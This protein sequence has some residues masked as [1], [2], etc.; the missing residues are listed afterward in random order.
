MRRRRAHPGMTAMVASGP[1]MGISDPQVTAYINFYKGQVGSGSVNVF[2]GTQFGYGMPVFAGAQ[3]Q[4][5]AGLGDFLRGIWRTVFPILAP[6]AFNTARSFIGSTLSAK[7]SGMGTKE[8]LAGALRPALETAL[9][10]T[11][12]ALARRRTEGAQAGGGRK[13][14][15]KKRRAGTGGVY[16]AAKKRCRSQSRRRHRRGAIK[17]Q[18]NF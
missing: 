1:G 18:S 16:K 2:K 7:D 10:S 9:T 4:T 14:R 12:E 11:G 3:F 6:V 17:L 8:A 15:G 5:G 13:R